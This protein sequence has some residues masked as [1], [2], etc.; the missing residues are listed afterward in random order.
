MWGT[1]DLYGRLSNGRS[2]PASCGP[3]RSAR[4]RSFERSAGSPQRLCG[5]QRS[6]LVDQLSLELGQ[7]NIAS[8]GNRAVPEALRPEI[9]KKVRTGLGF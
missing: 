3:R 5:R 7:V 6:G 2:R 9:E 4:G 8:H 1:S